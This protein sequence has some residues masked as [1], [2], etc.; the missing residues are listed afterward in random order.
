MLAHGHGQLWN[1]SQ[2]ATN[3]GISAPTARHYLDIL[4][5]T[6]IVRQLQPFHANLKK[7]LVKAPKVYLRDTGLLHVLTRIRSFDDLQAH[8]SL[9]SSWEGFVIEQL[10]NSV[11]ESWGRYFYRTSAGAEIDLLFL[12]G[13]NRPVPIEIKY[14]LSPKVSRGFWQA[15]ED[16]SCKRGFVIYP[17]QEAYPIGKNVYALPL[18]EID[19]IAG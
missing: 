13:R 6:F 1:A 5:E 17:G 4:E 11:P 12:D 2:M 19:I 14:S 8:P 15:F 3:L 16:L 9:G 18:K 10:M 7:R